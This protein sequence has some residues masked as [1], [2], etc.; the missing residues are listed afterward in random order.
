MIICRDYH[1]RHL[2]YCRDI[3]SLVKRTG[4][5]PAFADARQANEV[6]LSLEAFRHQRA[7]GD[8]DHRAEMANHG[9][10]VVLWSAPMDVA[11]A[12]AHW[13]LARA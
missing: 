3:H 1:Q 12:S 4:L 9:E 11:V 5:H 8:R 6:F 2:F 7:D 10:L 13:T